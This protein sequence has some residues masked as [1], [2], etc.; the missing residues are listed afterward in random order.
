MAPQPACGRRGLAR[1]SLR[2][3]RGFEAGLR[4]AKPEDLWRLVVQCSSAS[5][6]IGSDETHWWKV[7]R[8][9]EVVVVVHGDGSDSGDHRKAG[10]G[11][12][13][14]GCDMG[15]QRVFPLVARKADNALVRFRDAELPR[16]RKGTIAAGS[17]DHP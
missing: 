6:S 7:S 3:E 11:R 15:R 13:R 4:V 1:S 9:R 12:R 5:T 17:R 10:F 14:D 16:E 2:R 8:M